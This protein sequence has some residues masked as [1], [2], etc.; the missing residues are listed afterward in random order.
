MRTLLKTLVCCGGLLVAMTAYAQDRDDRYRDEGR[1]H[2]EARNESWWRGHL[3]QRVREDVEH[4]QEVS[5]GFRGDQ[6]RLD[7]VRQE[8]N[9]LQE[10]YS[11]R[12]YDQPELDDV[13]NALQRVVS[14]NQLSARDRDM[15]NDD[16]SRLREFRE[17]HEGYR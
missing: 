3:F 7:R 17:H 9:E 16:L 14:D 11:A 5:S 6:Y 15:L 1:Y 2:G 13:I 8:L 10:K 12:G 4:V